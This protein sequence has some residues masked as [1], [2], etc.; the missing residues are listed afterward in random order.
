MNLYTEF[1]TQSSINNP[2]TR[3]SVNEMRLNFPAGF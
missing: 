2:K 3:F 1:D